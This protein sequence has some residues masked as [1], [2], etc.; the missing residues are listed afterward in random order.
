[1]SP[2]AIDPN[3]TFLIR[4]KSDEEKKDPIGFRFRYLTAREFIRTSTPGSWTEQDMKDLGVVGIAKG[5]FDAIRVNYIGSDPYSEDLS[6]Q[7][8]DLEDILTINEAWELYYSS[9]RQSKLSVPEKND[10]ASPS[11]TSGGDSAPDA[12]ADPSAPIQSQSNPPAS[13]PAP[14][15]TKPDAPSATK[16][17]SS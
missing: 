3:E 12:E 11:A 2:L 9:R 17:T 15:A 1:M 6:I 14:D 7:E 16:E 5:L 4:L 10:S 8:K 13:S